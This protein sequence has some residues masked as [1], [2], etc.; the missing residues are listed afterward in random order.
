M[1]FRKEDLLSHKVDKTEFKTCTRQ[2]RKRLKLF[3]FSI[4]SFFIRRRSVTFTHKK[5]ITWCNSDFFSSLSGLRDF[6]HTK[7]KTERKIQNDYIHQPSPGETWKSTEGTEEFF[8][9]PEA[10]K[11]IASTHT[12]TNSCE[13]LGKNCLWGGKSL[14]W[15]KTAFSKKHPPRGE[16]KKQRDKFIPRL[17]CV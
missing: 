12:Y 1:T 4:I 7:A 2:A 10:E 6:Q 3:S 11:V 9:I 17:V 15:H 8:S 14:F 5:S 13:R 16:N